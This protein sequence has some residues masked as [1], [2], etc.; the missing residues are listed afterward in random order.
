MK[1][2]IFFVCMLFSA[3]C[4]AYDV[5]ITFQWD[6]DNGENWKQINFYV[7]QNDEPYNF[8]IPDETLLQEYENGVSKP[9]ELF[10]TWTFPDGQKTKLS[11]VAK[12]VNSEGKF[13]E[14]SNEITLTLDL[15]PLKTSSLE[16]EYSKVENA[17]A[18]KWSVID[19]R[20]MRYRIY[21]SENIEGPFEK[22]IAKL[23]NDDILDKELEVNIDNLFPDGKL[24][25]QYFIL[26]GF[27]DY[28]LKSE[29]SNVVKI[30]IDRRIIPVDKVLNFKLKLIPAT[31]GD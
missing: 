12:A 19:P 29:D 9:S 4:L 24:T 20:I 11:W 21:S 15:T 13:S 31:E 28:G 16:A 30:E 26:K 8:N 18:F 22:Q 14:E 23:E 17:I 5:A 1:K 6:S 27:S 10:R 25:T 2:I 3:N 7:R